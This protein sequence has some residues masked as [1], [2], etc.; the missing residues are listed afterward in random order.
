MK[1]NDELAI[2]D[3]VK[4]LVQSPQIA[5][6]DCSQEN[7]IPRKIIQFWDDLD[8]LPDDVK[9]CMDSWQG[10]ESTGI[11]RL[12]YDKFSARNF[13]E[14]ELGNAYALA[15]DK[16]YHPA[17]Q[18]DFFRL[19]YIFVKGGCYIDADDDSL[20]LPIDD[21]FTNG[22][23]K[24]QP[25]CY[26]V[27]S[28]SMVPPAVFTTKDDTGGGDN[29]IFYFNNNPLIA[30]KEHPIIKIALLSALKNL[31]QDFS[32]NLPEIQS[33]AGPGNLT[34]AVFEFS[35]EASSITQ[36]ITVLDNWG[37]VAESKWPLSYRD[38]VR[39]WRISNSIPFEWKPKT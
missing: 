28:H 2:S 21:F 22:C 27:Q 29:R 17:M 24:I 16:C 37:N 13:I 14:T 33:T 26:D 31:E 32:G 4:E 7:E 9:A 3:F 25:L 5:L 30:H 39:N 10:V 19:C 6:K 11:E 38:D 8:N 23:L 36:F 34:K 12:L 35:K 1:N 18:S 15:F 20:C